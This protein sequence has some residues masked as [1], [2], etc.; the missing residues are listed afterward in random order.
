MAVLE[1]IRVK[2]GIAITVII[3]LALLSFIVDPSTLQ[4][5]ANSMSSKYDVG[6]IGGKS[7]SYQDFQKDI[8]TFTAISEFTTGS[9]IK[10][11]EQQKGIRDAAWQAL[12]DKY[13]FVKNAKAAGLTV[14]DEELLALTSGDLMSSLFAQ[15]PYFLDENG[16]FSKDRLLQ[17]VQAVKDE[18]NPQLKAYW[19]Y[20]QESV[21]TQ[22]FY[23]KYGALFTASNFVN[24]LMTAKAVEENNNTYSV[25]FV[26]VPF[27]YAEDTTVTVSSSEIKNYYNSHKKM[28]K[29]NESR[30][31]EYVVF[32]VVP[33]AEDIQA[34]SDQV[35]ELHEEFA[36]TDNMKSFLLKNSD[37]PLDTRWYKEGELNSVYAPINDF[38]FGENTAASEILQNGNTFYMVKVLDNKNV[39]DSVFVKHILFAADN[40]AKA[41]S[42]LQLISTKKA[43]FADVAAEYSI[44]A[45]RNAAEPGDLG[46]FTQDYMIPGFE[47]VIDAEINKPY[48][49]NTQ[50][51]THIVL[52]SQKTKP[53]AK[54]QVA[55]FEKTAIP[56]KATYNTFYSQANDLAVRS[57]GKY[58]NYVKAVA[59]SGLYSHP[60]KN[61]LESNDKLGTVDN[62]REITRW[63]FEAKPGTVSDIVTV[64]NN[65]FF[66]AALAPKGI[67]KEGYATVEEASEAIRSILY[68]EKLSEKNGASVAEKVKDCTSMDAVATALNQTVSSKDDITFASLTSQGLDPKFIGAVCG[69]TEGKISQVNGTIGIY[70]FQVK[71]HDTGSFFTEDDAKMRAN[72]MMQ[73][74][75]QMLLPVMMNDADVK[76]HRARF[77]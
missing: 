73:Y 4:S 27:G 35:A 34:T 62:T 18:E 60:V 48:I 63:A 25:D 6:E 5:V 21:Y 69:A 75:S 44:D 70:V 20:L 51:G 29:Q 68:A 45:Q 71:S 36:T 49:V 47:S 46:W 67:H 28:F 65:F 26:M 3:A 52:V 31:I 55:L 43:A 12:I 13:L 41:D 38:V 53:V 58:E 77:F 17:F 54:K 15:N 33:S 24:P 9:T 42:L 2:F 72:Q 66:V 40:A 10:N 8:E 64:N 39:C 11:D 50:Y 1:K 56:S 16:Q 57:A 59:E 14:G 23:A 22:E 74:S 61:M 76:D 32:E 37:R 19:N 7:V 30:D